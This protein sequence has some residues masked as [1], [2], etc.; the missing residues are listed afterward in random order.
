MKTVLCTLFNSLYL[1]K[2]LVLYDS[3]EEVSSNFVL[4]ILC[5]DQECYDFF[6]KT[7][8]RNIVP[9][10]LN[11]IED[12]EMLIAKQNRSFGEYCWTS[13]SALILYVL[14]HFEEPICTYIDADMYFYNDP[15]LLVDEMLSNGAS[16]QMVPHRFTDRRSNNEDIVGKYCV[17][18]NT[19]KNDE[20]GLKILNHWHKQCLECCSNIGDGV[21]WGDQKYMDEW[22]GQPGVHVC[23]HPGAGVATWNIEQ[24]KNANG[25]YD[26]TVL[27]KPEG[28]TVPLVFYHF[29]ALVYWTRYHVGI[30]IRRGN[31]EIDYALVES[32]YEPYLKKIEKK[33]SLIEK[34]QCQLLLK[35]RNDRVGM[36]K[37]LFYSTILFQYIS[38]LS[39]AHRLKWPYIISVK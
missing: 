37:R 19:F 1:N 29:A 13:T 7:K 6:V 9:I 12:D 36:I 16:V 11:E 14:K 26:G 23:T 31:K 4:Y 34:S 38:K 5:M 15:Q 18:F 20:K 24:Y 2:G 10:Q 27:F 22:P 3:L 21:H 39:I 30:N 17:E 35:T 33:N 25:I 28:S 8:Y 32:L